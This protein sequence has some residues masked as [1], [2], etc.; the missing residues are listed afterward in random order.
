MAREHQRTARGAIVEHLAPA[1]SCLRG[2]R[3]LR[4]IPIR[5]ID[6]KQMMPDVANESRTLALA[7]H[8]E[9]NVTRRVTGRRIDLDEVVD[10]VRPAAD[11]IGAAML[12]DRHN[13]FAE[14]TQLRRP[15]LWINIDLGKIID[16]R[17]GKYVTRVGKGWYPLAVL[18]LCVPADMVVMQVRA[19]H[20]IDFLRPRAGGG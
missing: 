15:L 8:L 16:I 9:E 7:F 17:L 3:I 19:H 20:Q 12:K 11:E 6:L 10:P 13:A 2:V 1:Q 5:I 18:L 14:R 4:K